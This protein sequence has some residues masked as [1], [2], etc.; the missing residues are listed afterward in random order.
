MTITRT[1]PMQVLCLGM[2]RTGTQSLAD[3]LILLG[4]TP[5][6]HMR[7]VRKNGHEKYWLP[8]LEAKYSD[9]SRPISRAQFD[10]FLGDFAGVTDIPAAVF[11]S[12]LM[13]AYPCAKIILTTRSEE[14][15]FESMKSTLWHAKNSPFGETLGKYIWGEDREGEGKIRFSRHN[16]MVRNAAKE[17]GRE[18]LEFE[19]KDGWGPLCG[20]LGVEKP[21]EVGDGFP[22]S[23][24]WAEYKKEAL[25]KM[26]GEKAGK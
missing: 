11:A 9:P 15:W 14:S 25:M 24:D 17:R 4:I 18:I 20:F 21:Q 2:C 10:E 16:E 23:D 26:Q 1:I 7:E 5:V 12:E 8:L 19:V 6:Y 22:R 13:D 3:A